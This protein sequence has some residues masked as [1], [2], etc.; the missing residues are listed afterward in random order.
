MKYR[1]DRKELPY[2]AMVPDASWLAPYEEEGETT[3]DTKT[4]ELHADEV[5]GRGFL[6]LGKKL[7]K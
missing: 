4:G 1:I 5:H 6:L 7:Y 3:D 2:D